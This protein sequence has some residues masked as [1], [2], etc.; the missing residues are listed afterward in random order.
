MLHRLA[1][2]RRRLRR[3]R[4]VRPHL[5]APVPGAAHRRHGAQHHRLAPADVRRPDLRARLLQRA[6]LDVPAARCRRRSS[7][8][9]QAENE[10]R[11]AAGRRRSR[12]PPRRRRCRRP[13]ARGCPGRRS[14]AERHDTAPR[15][16]CRGTTSRCIENRTTHRADFRRRDAIRC[17]WRRC[18]AVEGNDADRQRARP[19]HT[20]PGSS[21]ATS[22]SSTPRRT[23]WPRR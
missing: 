19:T 20:C 13:A 2:D 12:A 22:R 1:V 3:H 21:A 4:A 7:E 10:V 18:A 11:D 5:G 23:R 8:F 16:R 17:T 9:W 14:R 15:R 6:G